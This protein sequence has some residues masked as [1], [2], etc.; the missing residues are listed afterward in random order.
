MSVELIEVGTG[1]VFEMTVTEGPGGK[2]TSRLEL[3]SGPPVSDEQWLQ[4]RRVVV[5]ALVDARFRVTNVREGY[6]DE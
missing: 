1:H 6:R 3:V 2:L 4:I 5:R